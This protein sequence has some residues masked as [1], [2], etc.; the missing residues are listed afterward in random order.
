MGQKSRKWNILQK[1]LEGY[2]LI[3]CSFFSTFHE[4]NLFFGQLFSN[5]LKICNSVSDKHQNIWFKK[6]NISFYSLCKSCRYLYQYWYVESSELE[7]QS[8]GSRFAKG[9]FRSL[10]IFKSQWLLLYRKWR[11]GNCVVRADG[12]ECN[13]VL[14]ESA[15]GLTY[16]WLHH[17]I[18]GYLMNCG[19]HHYTKVA[20]IAAKIYKTI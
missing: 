17:W 3:L 16:R 1:S 11:A 12:L 6:K 10:S 20:R 14:S 2:N 7:M 13:M 19:I 18:M 15:W 9:L 5:V 4:S 8:A